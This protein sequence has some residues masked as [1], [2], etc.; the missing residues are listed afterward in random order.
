VSRCARSLWAAIS[1]GRADLVKKAGTNPS[2]WRVN[3][4]MTSF[5]PKLIPTTFPTTNRP[6]YQQVISFA[7]KP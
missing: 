7:P 1:A 5:I 3:Q 4:G 6:T 2:A